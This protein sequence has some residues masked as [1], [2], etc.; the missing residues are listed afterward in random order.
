MTKFETLI[1]IF[2]AV[3]LMGAATVMF[4]EPVRVGYDCQLAEISPDIPLKYKEAC[5]KLRA[6][7]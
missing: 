4:D 3:F 6:V 7:K 1:F 2:V 5:R